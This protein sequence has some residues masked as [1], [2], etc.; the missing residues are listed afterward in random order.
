MKPTILRIAAAAGVLLSASSAH[1]LAGFS[2]ACNFRD[3]PLAFQSAGVV[4]FA[5]IGMPTKYLDLPT[6]SETEKK[7]HWILESI[8]VDWGSLRYYLFAENRIY[9]LK[10]PDSAAANWYQEGSGYRS[11]WAAQHLD[12]RIFTDSRLSIFVFNRYSFSA[13]AGSADYV[14]YYPKLLAWREADWFRVVGK[15]Y[16]YDPVSKAQ[17]NLGTSNAYDCALTVWGL[18]DRGSG[19]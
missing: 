16:Y 10:G 19:G 1:A 11:A 17:G 4:L 18:E 13:R 6:R 3:L 12:P 5:F 9:R 14:Q 7:Q 2:R 8:T 15:H